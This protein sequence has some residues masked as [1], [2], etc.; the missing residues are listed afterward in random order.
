MRGEFTALLVHIQEEPFQALEQGLLDLGIQT[1][2][3]HN[4]SEV[5]SA[6]RGA[7]PPGLVLTATTLVDGTWADVLTLASMNRG[8]VPVIIVSRLVDIDLYLDTLESGASDFIVPPLSPADLAHVVK[9]AMTRSQ[10]SGR[11]S[12]GSSL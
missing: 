1:Q 6:L 12:V 11:A 5:R 2:H 7:P 8:P 3:A 9:V 10:S 4:C